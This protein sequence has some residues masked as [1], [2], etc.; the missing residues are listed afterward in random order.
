[1][2]GEED[3]LDVAMEALWEQLAA[4]HPRDVLRCEHDAA[5]KFD[6]NTALE[7]LAPR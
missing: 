7:N 1:M 3:D 5:L 6:V 2:A 4:P